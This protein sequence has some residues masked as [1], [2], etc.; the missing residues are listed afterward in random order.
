MG[1]M[2]ETLMVVLEILMIAAVVGIAAKRMRMHYNIALVITGVIVGA[3]KL[4]PAV[5]LDPQIVLQIFL[6]ALL[7]EA[8]ISTDVRR[9]RENWAPIGLLAVPGMLI[10][11]FVAGSI[12]AAGLPVGWS[13]ALVLGAIL[14]TTDTIAVIASFRKVKVPARLESIV[15][16]ESLLN[17]GTA[18]VA[19]AALLEAY[20]RGRF[21]PTH[22]ALEL[23]WVSCGGLAAGAAVGYAASLLMSRT[24]DHL[25][26]I[27]LTV[28]VAYGAAFLGERLHASPVLAVVT[29]GLVVGSFGWKDLRPTGKVAIRSFWEVAA[30][31]VNSVVFLLIGLAV[32]FRALW[33]A[34]TMIGWGLLALT[35]GRALAV[36]PLLALLRGVRTRVPLR[37]Q[38]LLV[39]GNLKGS[40]SM[41]L[42]LSLPAD[43]PHRDLLVTVVFGC[44][45]VTL[46]AQGLTLGPLLRAMGMGRLGETERRV[47]QE[48]AQLLAARAGQAELD[49]LQ[50]MG[51]LAPGVFQRMRAAYQGV[52]ARTERSLRDVLAIHSHEEKRYSQSLRRHL[53]TVE[54]SALRDAVASGIV[55]EEVASE[56]G[57]GID[58]Q[59]D[60][61]V[62]QQQEG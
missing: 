37:W 7:F 55:S 61:I 48:Q 12:L 20:Q 46:T 27:M 50:Q 35:L 57:A 15:E 59:L 11:V 33:D 58:K 60:Q 17:D 29:A 54:K 62:E 38:H 51:L 19:F 16:N 41:A 1:A 34:R 32:D 2:H 43:L 4:I 21:E 30:F 40:L 10:T 36:Y 47:E 52:I 49:R 3:T 44:T 25:V 45:I 53:L 6:P 22:G 18:L 28:L 56:I 31:G 39:W 24:H 26:E 13:L 23:L 9:L 8:A 5:G 42:V 14:A